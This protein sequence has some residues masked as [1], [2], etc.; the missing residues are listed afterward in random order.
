MNILKHSVIIFIL[1]LLISGCMFL[2]FLPGDY[3]AFSVPLSAMAQFGAFA[4][5]LFVPI[6]LIWLVDEIRRRQKKKSGSN[7]KNFAFTVAALIVSGI[8]AIAAATAAFANHSLSAGL[9]FLLISGC[10][11]FRIAARSKK[12]VAP[13][14]NPAPVYLLVI[15]IIVFGIRYQCIVRAAEYS[16]EQAIK[17]S[18]PLIAD[19][20]S[21]YARNGFYPESLLSVWEDYKPAVRGIKRFYYERNG[22]AYNLF[23]EQFSHDPAAKEIV[24]YNNLDEHDFSSHNSDLIKLSPAEILQ[25]RGYFALRELP[26]SHWKYFLFD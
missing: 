22:K 8:V 21:F 1:I 7:I 12:A 25:Q 19:I 6:G 18:A 17:N 5:L 23:F 16:K 11:I 20:E 4:G 24:M 9:I 10:I 14:F 3:D 26:V 2:P 13:G 15:P